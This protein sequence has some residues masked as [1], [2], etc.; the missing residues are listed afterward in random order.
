MA[1]TLTFGIM[2]LGIAFSVTYALTGSLAI[3]GA[4][5]FIEPAVNTVAHYF[6]DRYWEKR[7]RRQAGTARNHAAAQRNHANLAGA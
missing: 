5:T 4:I 7:E 1:K 3:S 6:F 2:H